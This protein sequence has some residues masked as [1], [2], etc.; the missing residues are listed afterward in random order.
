MVAMTRQVVLATAALAVQAAFLQGYV[1]QARVA[2]QA[3]PQLWVGSEVLVGAWLVAGA[4][5]MGEM[6]QALAWQG[7]FVSSVR[8]AQC[9]QVACFAGSGWWAIQASWQRGLHAGGS[10]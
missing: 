8:S 3:L 7:L 10:R 5:Q 1:Q 2:V 9:Q 4:V 6:Q